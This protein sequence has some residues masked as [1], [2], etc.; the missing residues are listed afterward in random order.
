MFLVEVDNY[1]HRCINSY[2]HHKLK[3]FSQSVMFLIQSV[4]LTFSILIKP[5]CPFISSLFKLGFQIKSTFPCSLQT[6]PTHPYVH[7][8]IALHDCL[9]P[10]TCNMSIKLFPPSLSLSAVIRPCEDCDTPPPFSTSAMDLQSNHL[11]R[12]F[13]HMKMF[14]PLVLS[15]ITTNTIRAPKGASKSFNLWIVSMVISLLPGSKHLSVHP[16]HSKFHFT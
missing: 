2:F 15:L 8:I 7:P 14:P 4:N 12:S 10:V 13:L 1:F 5:Q 16:V 11:I 6:P 9:Q 3:M